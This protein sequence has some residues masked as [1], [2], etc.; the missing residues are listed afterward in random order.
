MLSCGQKQ[1]SDVAV[2]ILQVSEDSV[3]GGGILCGSFGSESSV[4]RVQ[5]GRDVVCVVENC[6]S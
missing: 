2:F 3:I 4:V 6:F 5:A 1:H